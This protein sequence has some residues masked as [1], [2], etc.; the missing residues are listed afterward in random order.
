MYTWHRHMSRL[1]H[2]REMNGMCISC[3]SRY[4]HKDRNQRIEYEQHR[5]L[6]VDIDTLK[7]WMECV[8][9]VWIDM[10]T[11]VKINRMYSGGI[12]IWIDVDTVVQMN[13][14]YM[15]IDI[16]IIVEMNAMYMNGAG[17]RIDIDIDRDRDI[18]MTIPMNRMY[19]HGTCDDAMYI[20]GTWVPRLACTLRCVR[21]HIYLHRHMHMHIDVHRHTRTL[22]KET[23]NRERKKRSIN[24]I[25]THA[26]SDR[27]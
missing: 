25:K 3:R 16:D 21:I 19:I 15:C 8:S 26:L 23:V 7:R 14:M 4:G 18:D 2:T 22:K 6:W 10:D 24:S 9:V 11:I 17:T 20:H 27:I 13:G 1:R 5:L 12:G